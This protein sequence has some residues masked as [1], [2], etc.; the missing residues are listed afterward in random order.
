MRLDFES[1]LKESHCSKDSES[2]S[3]AL[4]NIYRTQGN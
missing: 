1:F 4:V 3:D 2:E